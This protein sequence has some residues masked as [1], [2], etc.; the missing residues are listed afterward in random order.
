MGTSVERASSS[1]SA[2]HPLPP[3]TPSSPSTR[4]I[5]SAARSPLPPALS[6]GHP[7]G[8]QRGGGTQGPRKQRL[9]RGR[10]R[11]R[12]EALQRRD[13][14]GP[15]GPHLLLQPQRVLRVRGEA[16]RRGERRGAMHRAQAGVG[17]RVLA[18]GDGAV[19]EER[20]RRRAKGTHDC[21]SLDHSFRIFCTRVIFKLH[22]N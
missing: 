5:P 1:S 8:A 9:R 20:S 22:H 4:A 2:A 21:L 12:R 14:G 6:P 18:A 19:Q 15:D 17:E 11:R 7:R 16:I 13:R 10:L 3:L